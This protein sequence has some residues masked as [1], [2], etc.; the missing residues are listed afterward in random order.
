MK[1]QSNFLTNYI[2]IEQLE[3]ILDKLK[4]EEIHHNETYARKENQI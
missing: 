3:Y 1:G 2:S 4:H